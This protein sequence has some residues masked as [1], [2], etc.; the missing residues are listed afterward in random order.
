MNK[1][2]FITGTDTGVGKTVVT[3]LLGRYFSDKGVNVVTQK[4]IQTGCEGT[5]EDILVHEEVMG[6]CFK[7]FYSLMVPYIFK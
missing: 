1:G 2:I 4:W 5:S 7:E 3:G 6:K